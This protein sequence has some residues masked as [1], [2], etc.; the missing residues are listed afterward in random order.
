MEHEGQERPPLRVVEY[1]K[2]TFCS[3]ML[4]YTIWAYLKNAKY[5]ADLKQKLGSPAIYSSEEFRLASLA[6]R[7]YLKRLRVRWGELW[8]STECFE[9]TS[10]VDTAKLYQ[11]D[12]EGY[13]REVLK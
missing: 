10:F 1:S 8:K 11:V 4:D 9:K 13:N 5:V 6:S 3:Y 2:F 7:D 12:D